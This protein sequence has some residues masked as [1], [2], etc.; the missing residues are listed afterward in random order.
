MNKWFASIG[1]FLA[2]AAIPAITQNAPLPRGTVDIFPV[3]RAGTPLHPQTQATPAQSGEA[4]A[5]LTALVE[6]ALQKN[7]AV[8][9]ALRRVEAM[10]H[11]IRQAK[12]WPDPKVGVGWMGNAT[13]FSVQHGDPSSY[14]GVQA[15]QTIP[16]PGK[17]GLRGNVAGKEAEA[18]SW[19]YEAVRRR[20]TAD[21]KAAYFEYYF[22]EKAIQI[23]QKNRDLL[24]KLSQIAEARYRVGK[25]IQQDVLKAQTEL[26]LIMRRLTV[27]DQQRQ[28]AQARL[29]TLLSQ[30]ADATVAAPAELEPAV[31]AYSLDELYD[32]AQKND[33]G[34]HRDEQVIQRDQYAV[35]LA[36][37]EY[38]P[39]LGIGYMYQQRPDMPDM[40][41]VTFTVNIPIFYK[42]KQREAVKQAGDELLS[43][44][45]ARQNRL[46]EVEFDV[47]QQYLEA[48]ASQE[49]IALYAK[50][51]VPQASLALESSMSAYQVGKADFLTVLAN[52]TNVLQY[53]V[54][55]YRELANFETALARLEPRVGIELTSNRPQ[56]PIVPKAQK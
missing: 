25:G 23:T 8:Q 53:Q 27:L 45:A 54:E 13:P 41:G 2:V 40:H 26:S 12:S 7:P 10:R 35:N 11:R 4:N 55:Y 18:A 17:L 56:S 52:F 15:M 16:F 49:L 36:H 42:S 31:L 48:Q 43:S 29:N 50:G 51:I 20:V 22:Y 19:D 30:S 21:V 37:K 34:L 5:S 33:P 39:D 6:E 14:R 24:T 46:N 38:Y 28:T 44:Q 3:H 9:S 47:K 1:F 32:L